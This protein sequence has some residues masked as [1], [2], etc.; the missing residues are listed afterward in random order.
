MSGSMK[1]YETTTPEQDKILAELRAGLRDWL[2][3][4]DRKGIDHSLALT[5]LMLF[6]SSGAAGVAN[7]TREEFLDLLGKYFDLYRANIS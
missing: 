6:T 7:I 3:G 1:T 4:A 2:L 5:A